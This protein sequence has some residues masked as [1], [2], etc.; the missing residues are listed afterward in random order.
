LLRRRVKPEF[1]GALDFHSRIIPT[2]CK[3]SFSRKEDAGTG[4]ALRDA[5]S[6]AG[7]NAGVSRAFR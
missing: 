6:L 3:D 2:F 1:V 4:H 5:L 7:M